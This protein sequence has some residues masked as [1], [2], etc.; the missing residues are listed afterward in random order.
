MNTARVCAPIHDALLVAAGVVLAGVEVD[1]DVE[2]I[3]WLDRHADVRRMVMWAR[4]TE[5]LHAL[6]G[7]GGDQGDES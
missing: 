1:T 5:I 4:V 3:A 7:E 6:E 2:V